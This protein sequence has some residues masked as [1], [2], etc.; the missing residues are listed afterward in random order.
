M[1]PETGSGVTPAWTALVP[2]P[3]VL[4]LL[5]R[6]AKVGKGIEEVRMTSILTWKYLCAKIYQPMLFMRKNLTNPAI[7][8][9][10]FNNLDL[11]E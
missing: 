6:G 11:L 10:R 1:A 8:A 7:S 4:W 9:Q 5:I 3:C 2:K